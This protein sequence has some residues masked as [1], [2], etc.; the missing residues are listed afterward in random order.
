MVIRS[1]I[2]A[3]DSRVNNDAEVIK[4]FSIFGLMHP[5]CFYFPEQQR[6]KLDINLRTYKELFR[7]L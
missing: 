4:T 7:R 5:S 2:Q 1:I 6:H 3:T